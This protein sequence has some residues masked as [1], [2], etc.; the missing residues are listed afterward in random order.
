MAENKTLEKIIEDATK[1]Q[2]SNQSLVTT[3]T[4]NVKIDTPPVI[5]LEHVSKWF[6]TPKTNDK[7]AR[8]DVVNDVNLVV[9]NNIN[10]EFIA[11]LGPS[12]C[13]KSTILNM[14]AGQTKPSIGTVKTFGESCEKDNPNAVTVQQ[15]YTCFDW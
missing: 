2:D 7:H 14:L 13:G 3:L 4:Q 1:A 8:V 6:D 12:G 10:G 5:E 11:I 15:A 9:E